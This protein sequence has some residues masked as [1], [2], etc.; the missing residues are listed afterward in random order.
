MPCRRQVV[1]PPSLRRFPAE[2]QQRLGGQ[3]EQHPDDAA[4]SEASA[5]KAGPSPTDDSRDAPGDR[6]GQG[7]RVEPSVAEAPNL[8]A[9]K[10]SVPSGGSQA[11]LARR[12]P[13][14]PTI[15]ASETDL[16][17]LVS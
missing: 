3:C 17:V 8:P 13:P 1:D 11:P 14:S 15:K 6:E 4:G 7:V 12:P 9:L 10:T 16:L 5:F 2:A